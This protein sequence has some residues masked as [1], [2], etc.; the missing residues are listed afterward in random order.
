MT[1]TTQLRITIPA[2]LQEFLHA[3]A[4]KYGL[5]KS[6]YVKNLIL[7]DVKDLDFP[8]YPMSKKTEKIALQALTDYKQGKTHPLGDIDEF[9]NQL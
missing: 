9:L 5:S 1:S 7:N 8:T 6:A 3:K 4:S 2:E